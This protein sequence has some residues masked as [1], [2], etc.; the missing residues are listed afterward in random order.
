MR[1]TDY[2]RYQRLQ[3][4]LR[5]NLFYLERLSAARFM[6]RRNAPPWSK[7]D[8][9]KLPKYLQFS[10]S[11]IRLFEVNRLVAR[12]DWP[13]YFRG[14]LYSHYTAFPEPLRKAYRNGYLGKAYR[15]PI[16]K[17]DMQNGMVCPY[18]LEL[19][20]LMKESNYYAA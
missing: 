3:D 14:R 10:L 19:V 12:I 17:A 2:K 15:V 1:N 8:F 11:E 4:E 13:L 6:A 5:A 18:S 16:W 7:A 20:K 9:H